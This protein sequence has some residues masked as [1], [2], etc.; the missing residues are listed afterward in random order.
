[1]GGVGVGDGPQ[2]TRKTRGKA[3][4]SLFLTEPPFTFAISEDIGVCGL[5]ND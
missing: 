4:V 3:A 5:S 1:M 2:A